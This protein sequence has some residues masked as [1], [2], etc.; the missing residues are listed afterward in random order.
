MI[1][2]F[3]ESVR[4]FFESTEIYHPILAPPTII[5]EM[6]DSMNPHT[7][8]TIETFDPYEKPSHTII[9]FGKKENKFGIAQRRF[10]IKE[11]IGDN[12][13]LEPFDEI[14]SEEAREELAEFIVDTHQDDIRAQSVEVV[15]K[16][17]KRKDV[18]ILEK[19]K[20]E[21]K[22]KKKSKLRTRMGCVFF[23]IG[24]ES[25]IL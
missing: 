10:K 11:K 8:L 4:Q 16:A 20:I 13:V 23:E 19:M 2:Q 17:L 7:G 22:K 25:I 3:P 14:G 21:T 15:K 18:K 24:E 9:L 5:D 6:L 1:E 12:I